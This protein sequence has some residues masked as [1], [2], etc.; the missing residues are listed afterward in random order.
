MKQTLL[1]RIGLGLLLLTGVFLFPYWLVI[2]AGA[3]SAVFIPYYFE[4][5]GLVVI[6]EM[7]YHTTGAVG[8][9]FLYP[10]VL[11]VFFILLE[12]G[13]SLVRERFLRI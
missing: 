8:T 7:L 4:F 1:L 9:S 2:I 11:F 3:V 12:A 13:R 10:V 6:E 5:I